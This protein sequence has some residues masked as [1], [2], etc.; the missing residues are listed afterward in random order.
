MKGYRKG[1]LAVLLTLT[2]LIGGCTS[3]NKSKDKSA[4]ETWKENRIF[5]DPN[6]THLF[7][8]QLAGV[9]EAKTFEEANQNFQEALFLVEEM[10]PTDTF[11]ILLDAYQEVFSPSIVTD[12]FVYEEKAVMS[13]RKSAL[14]SALFYGNKSLNSYK[15]LKDTSGL[16]RCQMI[17][18]SVHS[19]KGDFSEALKY[20]IKAVELFESIKDQPGKYDAISEMSVNFYLEGRYKEA[21]KLASQVLTYAINSKDTF[22]HADILNSLGS[23]YHQLGKQKESTDAILKSIEIRKGLND[24]FG[25]GQS[26]NGLAVTFMS[27]NRWK[28]ALEILSKAEEIAISIADTRNLTSLYY[29]IGTCYMELGIDSKAE[30]SFL[31]VIDIT[32]NSGI[33]DEGLI[34]CLQRISLLKENQGDYRNAYLYSKKLNE[35]KSELF[36]EEKARI[37]TELTTKYQ[38]KEQHN[39]LVISENEKKRLQEKR[40]IMGF[41]LIVVSLLSI[42]LVLLLIQRNKNNKKL[43]LAEQKLKDE[44]VEKIQRELQYNREQLNDFTNHLV[45]KNKMIFEL[46]K[47]LL[48]LTEASSLRKKDE[49]DEDSEEYASLLQLRI[50]TDDDW[51]KFKIYFDKVFPG[52]ILHLRQEH[53]HVTGAEERLFLLLRLKTDSREMAEMLGISMESVRKNKYRLKKKLQLDEN[54][55]LEEYISSF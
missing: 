24:D 50:L 55:N 34:R 22:L 39:S 15:E 3:D 43:H 53:P 47:K 17:V 14:D 13:L 42:S 40:L 27:E 28:D 54:Q 19:F 48:N 52:L 18:A 49:N 4:E 29:N 23:I 35:L 30:N 38:V 20:Q 7:P 37:T 1:L 33:K 51:S 8:D 11:M 45:E 16:A 32:E 12:A 21:E 6:I 5:S 2:M 44:A 46:E 31:K 25:L 41:A 9:I 26:Y 10:L 36:T